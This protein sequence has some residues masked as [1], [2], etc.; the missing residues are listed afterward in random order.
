MAA[1]A[2]ATTVVTATAAVATATA[3]VATAAVAAAPRKSRPPGQRCAN[4]SSSRSSSARNGCSRRRR[5][6]MAGEIAAGAAGAAGAA[7][8]AVRREPAKPL[9][10]GRRPLLAKRRLLPSCGRASENE[11]EGCRRIAAVVPGVRGRDGYLDQEEEARRSRSRSRK[12]DKPHN[13]WISG[14]RV[15]GKKGKRVTSRQEAGGERSGREDCFLRG[16]DPVS[17]SYLPGAGVNR[18]QVYVT[19]VASILGMCAQ[20]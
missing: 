7:A 2:A 1:V 5:Q 8:F 9:G 14:P 12:Q 20:F 3:A 15:N 16:L 6:R 18:P 10:R 11:R 19:A 17:Q 4:S 13:V